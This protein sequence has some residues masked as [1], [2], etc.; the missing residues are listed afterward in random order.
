MAKKL[1]QKVI[2]HE[3][4]D[5]SPLLPMDVA[6]FN[7]DGTP[8]TGGGGAAPG[9]A[10]TTTAGLVKKA[11]ATTAVASPDATA[12]ANETVTKEEF[13]KVVALANE[14]KAQLNDLI[15]K[16]KSAGQMA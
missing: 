13:D 7:E 3:E 1:V 16:A 12:A 10:T 8:F 2:V 5:V 9:N 14:C 11:S 6:L 4:A 15:T